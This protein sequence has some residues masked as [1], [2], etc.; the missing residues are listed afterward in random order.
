M[1]VGTGEGGGAITTPQKSRV[2]KQRHRNMA[3][4]CS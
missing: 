1:A 3:K 2:L 4:I